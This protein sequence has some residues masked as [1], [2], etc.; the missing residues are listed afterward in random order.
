MDPI[1]NHHLAIDIGNS[2]AK[3]AVFRG[4][5]MMEPIVRFT[6]QQWAVADDLVTNRGVK[7]IIYSTV[8]N[9]PPKTWIDKWESEGRRIVPLS[10]KLPLP[11]QSAYQTMETLGQDRIAVVAASLALPAAE[12][13][14][15]KRPPARLIVDA[16]TCATLDLVDATGK[17]LGGNI[18]PGLHM[19]LQAMHTFTARLPLPEVKDPLGIVGQSTASALRHGGLMGLVYEIEGLFHRLQAI[20]PGLELLLTG[21]DGQ[22]LAQRLSIPARFYPHLVLLGLNQILSNY[23]EIES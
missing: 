2:S 8:A 18:S 10:V 21:G 13:I 12:G 22:W 4:A 23:V 1:S 3:A 17:Y 5:Q 11:F 15:G 9:V 14:S 16:G 19:R 6:D 7:N 20:Y